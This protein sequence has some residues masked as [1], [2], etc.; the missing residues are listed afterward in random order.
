MRV[1]WTRASS[2]DLD[3]IWNYL[4]EHHPEFTSSTI[5]TIYNDVRRLAF[6]PRLGRVGREEGTRELVISGLPYI[7]VYRVK[8]E[9]V[10]ILHIFHGAQDWM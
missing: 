7:A 8:D 3:H 2:V 10:E 1:R 4:N 9:S 5:R 6:A